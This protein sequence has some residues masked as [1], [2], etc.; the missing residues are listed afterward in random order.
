MYRNNNRRKHDSIEKLENQEI[1]T[2]NKKEKKIRKREILEKKKE[3]ED[4]ELE[5]QACTN[6][7][8][9]SLPLK[10]LLF[11]KNKKCSYILTIQVHFPQSN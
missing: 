3:E 5:W 8:I 9:P 7:L 4:R 2:R 10:I 1:E 11:T 6:R